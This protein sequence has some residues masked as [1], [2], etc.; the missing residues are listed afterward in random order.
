M[1][2]TY[3]IT[4]AIAGLLSTVL[5]SDCPA[6]VVASKSTLR[7]P[8]DSFPTEAT[9]VAGLLIR[10]FAASLRGLSERRSLELK[11]MPERLCGETCIVALRHLTRL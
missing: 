1:S 5:V 3:R 7:V 10:T 6:E 11:I 2:T 8:L 9:R 4:R